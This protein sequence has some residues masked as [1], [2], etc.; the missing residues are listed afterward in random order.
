LETSHVLF[1]KC[2][3]ATVIKRVRYWQWLSRSGRQGEPSAS[4]EKHLP[5]HPLN[6]DSFTRGFLEPSINMLAV[7]ISLS[8]GLEG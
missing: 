8:Q 7:C 3:R 2:Y 6:K 1:S 5:D 4:T